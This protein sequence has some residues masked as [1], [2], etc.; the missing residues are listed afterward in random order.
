MTKR[1]AEPSW[2][3]T[4]LLIAAVLGLCAVPVLA[5]QGWWSQLSFGAARPPEDLAQ[6]RLL[7]RAALITAVAASLVGIAAGW[8]LRSTGCVVVMSLVLAGSMVF[9]LAPLVEQSEPAA[10]T[11]P[12]PCQERSG[13]DNDCPGG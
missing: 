5:Y 7:L 12:L 10:P 8:W 11:G 9:V 3:A 4:L 6:S 1:G 13:G 2:V